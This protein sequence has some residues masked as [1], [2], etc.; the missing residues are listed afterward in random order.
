MSP[1][2][3]DPALGDLLLEL[4]AMP[5]LTGEEGPIAD[6]LVRRYRDE[7]VRRVGNSLVVGAEGD[8]RPTVLLVGHIDVVPPT[9]AD[10]TPRRQGER[11]VGRGAS[12]MKSGLAVAM[13]CFEDRALRAGA[14]HLVLVAYAAEE[15][16]HA[17]NEL[18]AVLR[19]VPE[20]ADAV[21]AVVLEPTDLTVQLG[22]LGV[23]NAEVTVAGRAAHAARPWQGDN[24]LTKAAGLLTELAGLPPEDRTLDGLVYREVITPTQAWTSNA[25]NVVPD[26]FSINL[27]YRFAPDRSLDQAEQRLRSLLGDRPA[28]VEIVDRAPA[29][30][31]HRHAP[32]V[33]AFVEAVGA[34]VEPKQAW[35]DVARFSELGVP[36]LNYGPGATAQA[37]QAGEFVPEANLA[38]ARERLTRF[39]AA[40]LR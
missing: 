13:D 35:T 1:P 9:D 25:R 34:P 36:A 29:G 22:C 20:L 18:A 24:A 6:W 37:H 40:P 5:C 8:P 26:R 33:G 38:A 11:I 21:L 27:N 30:R 14:Y 31:P 15:G 3:L 2:P 12:D 28:S 23:L 32:A 10:R 16:T 19:Q 39:L 7:P 4:L 17:G